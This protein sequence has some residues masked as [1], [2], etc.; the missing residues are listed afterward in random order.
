[1]NNKLDMTKKSKK[2]LISVQTLNR[3]LRALSKPT[4]RAVIKGNRVKKL[5]TTLISEIRPQ[6][7]FKNPTE[8]QVKNF[9]T[10]YKNTLITNN[11]NRKKQN[12][13]E[14][15]KIMRR[16]DFTKSANTIFSKLINKTLSLTERQ[17]KKFISKIEDGK[18]LITFTND[19]DKSISVAASSKKTVKFLQGL[20]DT[21]FQQ[22]E[23]IVVGAGQFG[24]DTIEGFLFREIKEISIKE[25]P[26][27]NKKLNKNGAFFKYINKSGLDLK[28]LQI[29]DLDYCNNAHKY[30]RE[31]C[32]I[33]SLILQGVDESLIKELKLASNMDNYSMTGHSFKKSHIKL[34]PDIINKNIKICEYRILDEG[35]KNNIYKCDYFQS[36]I[37]PEQKKELSK[38]IDNF[39]TIAMFETHYFLYE[40][41]TI[42]SKFYIDN[43]EKI[44]QD[45]SSGAIKIKEGKSKFDIVKLDKGKYP[46][47]NSK[48]KINS[49]LLV[50]KLFEKGLFVKGDLSKFYEYNKST[51]DKYK[52][53]MYSLENLPKT[54]LKDSKLVKPINKPINKAIN[55]INKDINLSKSGKETFIVKK[56][57]ADIESYVNNDKHELAMLGF[58]QDKIIKQSIDIQKNE[59]IGLFTDSVE[60]LNQKDFTDIS[61]LLNTFF[62]IITSGMDKTDVVKVYF[63]NLKYD[64][65]VIEEH[66]SNLSSVCKK[67]GQLYQ[68]KLYGACKGACKIELIDSYK[69]LPFKLSDFNKNLGLDKSLNKKE[70]INYNYYTKENN[71]KLVNPK[72]YRQGLNNKLKIVFDEVSKPFLNSDGLFDAWGYYQEYLKY[73]CLTL[74]A[75]MEKMNEIILDIT[76]NEI[77][78]Y[79]KLTISSLANHYMKINGAF[80][81]VVETGGCIRDYIAKAV[82]GGRVHV[83]QKYKK[84]VL[85]KKIADYDGVSLYP[86]AIK[87]LCDQTGLPLG[88]PMRFESHELNRWTETDYCVLTVKIN[89][90]NKFQQ[91]PMIAIKKDDI[92]TDYVNTIKEPVIVVIDK[93]TLEDYIKFHEIDYEIIDGLYYNNGFNK[94]MGELISELFIS[95][96]KYKKQGNTG[97]SNVLKLMMNSSYGKTIM[98]KSYD[99]INIIDGEYKNELNKETGEYEKVINQKFSNYIHNNYSTIEEVRFIN[100][101]KCE[102]KQSQFDRS[103]NLSQVGT[104]ILSMSKRIMNEVFDVCN[105]NNYPIY[106]TD[107]DSLHMDYDD[108][109]KFEEKFKQEYNRDITGKQ[110][111]QFHI[112]FDLDG[113]GKNEDIYA[114]KSIFLGKKSYYD[115]LVSKDDDGNLITGEHVRMKGCTSEGLLDLSKKHDG[116]ENVYEK[117]AKGDEIEC[118]LNPY[119][120]EDNS[121]KVMFDFGKKGVVTRK[122][123]DF[124]RTLKF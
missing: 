124:I 91:M 35:H 73:D 71:G 82:F 11:K 48:G 104:S 105:T 95:R 30:E 12:T 87:R 60:I 97:M 110:L 58:T 6:G 89:K 33:H 111:G 45:I 94:K 101:F 106:Y 50:K 40:D 32:L 43:I 21:G 61:H 15:T 70:A 54:L 63:H 78:V 18:K 10:D 107:T 85:N 81:G 9:L 96:L 28:Y 100:D 68:V 1:M 74:K 44:E 23:K 7:A 93:Y 115:K 17:L 2:D 46:V 42:Y 53:F 56:V 113:A 123:G 37:S 20:I 65:N 120:E 16:K 98:K 25:L 34:V 4:N 86:S 49:L 114:T 118:V 5:N 55:N 99:K 92:S 8:Q 27:P 31:N 51:D 14:F 90:I 121:E 22:T 57:Y 59:K 3:K 75:G 88:V 41:N 66:L 80:E 122:C 83:N 76:N 67:D 24:S 117:L 108:V 19:K 39:L 26:A 119:N 103:G 36:N 13:K 112:D 84:K 52:G 64:Y 69:L 72:D 47:Y 29:Y 38:N 102:I 109:N 116:I 79:D 62:K 77:S